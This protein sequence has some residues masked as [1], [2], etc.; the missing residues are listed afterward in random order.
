MHGN[1]FS[2]RPLISSVGSLSNGGIVA[3]FGAFYYPYLSQLGGYI[4]SLCAVSTVLV[5]LGFAGAALSHNVRNLME[6]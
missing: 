3:T 2:N 4:T 1:E 6:L 5:V